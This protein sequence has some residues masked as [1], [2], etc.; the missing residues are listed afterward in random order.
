MSYEV[1]LKFPLPDPAPV[2]AAV[3]ELGGVAGEPLVQADLYFNHPSRNF[4]QTHEAFRIRSSGDE[5][6]ITYKGPVVDTQAK[7]REEIELEFAPG[8]AARDELRTLLTLLGFR[9]VLEVR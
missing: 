7:V 8:P 5:N 2:L 3:R 6:C 4:A 9:P 1:E